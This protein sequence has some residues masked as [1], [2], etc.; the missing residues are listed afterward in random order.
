MTM[1][2]LDLYVAMLD[3]AKIKVTEDGFLEQRVMGERKPA[4]LKG[5]SIVLPT[6]DQLT[7]TDWTNR[8]RFHPLNEN[9]LRGES[10]V[11]TF[12]RKSLAIRANLTIALVA[13]KL[14]ELATSP[15]EHG[16]LSPEQAEFLS[17]VKNADE[18]TLDVFVKLI[19]A[20]PANESFVSIFLKRAGQIGGRRHARVGVVSFPIYQALKAGGDV[21]GVKMRVKDRESLI[22]LLEYMIPTIDKGEENYRGSDSQIAPFCDALMKSMLVIAAPMNAIVELFR[23]QFDD[24]EGEADSLMFNDEWVEAFDNLSVMKN[25]IRSIPMQ[26]GNDGT[27]IDVDGTAVAMSAAPAAVAAPVAAPAG[28]TP[29][30]MHAQIYGTPAAPAAPVYPGQAAPMHGHPPPGYYNPHAPQQHQ[31]YPNPGYGAPGYPPPGHAPAPVVQDTGR[32]L[33]FNSLIRANGQ[34]AAT[35]GAIGQPAPFHAQQ[36]NRQPSW[37][38]PV[39]QAYGPTAGVP[40]M[41][42]GG[43]RSMI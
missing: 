18:K 13:M 26:D 8:T 10:D 5:K 39:Q 1:K 31:H 6:R 23:N 3:L 4:V 29:G 7:T 42:M 32:G 38:S 33:D 15:A 9:V 11:L 16:K 22:A 41:P 12:F 24:S 40:A 14:L 36:Q 37:A 25:E 21:K 19:D 35:V 30:S 20:H 28:P 17:K 34:L 2:L 27:A 43:Y